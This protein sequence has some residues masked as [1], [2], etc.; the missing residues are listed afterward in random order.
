MAK[1]AICFE[2]LEAI[3]LSGALEKL[4]NERI[5]MIVITVFFIGL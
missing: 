1:Y 4:L 5:N 2:L 3:V